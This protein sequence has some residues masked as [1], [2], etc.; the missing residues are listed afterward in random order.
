[1]LIYSIDGFKSFSSQ[2]TKTHYAPA[3]ITAFDT[4]DIVNVGIIISSVDFRFS[5]FK[6]INN[7]AYPLEHKNALLT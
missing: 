5:F 6:A 2:S 7:A 1:M 4:A 3:S